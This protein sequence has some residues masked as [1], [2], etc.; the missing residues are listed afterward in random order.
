MDQDIIK[1]SSWFADQFVDFYNESYDQNYHFQIY[2]AGI[3]TVMERVRDYLDDVGF[4]YI[5]QRQ[6]EDFLYELSET[7]WNL[8]RCMKLN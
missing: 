7:E 8:S 2:T 6:K 3:R 1:S 5:P 4:V